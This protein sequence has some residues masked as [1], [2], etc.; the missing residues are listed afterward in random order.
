MNCRE[1]D[2]FLTHH[3]HPPGRR[4]FRGQHFKV[5][6]HQVLKWNYPLAITLQRSR[7]KPGNQREVGREGVSE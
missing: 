4:S 2:T 3:S 5:T 6:K 7:V 1:I